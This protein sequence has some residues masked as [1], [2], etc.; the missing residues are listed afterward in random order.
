MNL[1]QWLER[2]HSV[3]QKLGQTQSELALDGKILECQD[4]LA[5]AFA[6]NDLTYA[7]FV[8]EREA[9][10][11]SESTSNLTPRRRNLIP[12]TPDSKLASIQSI[13]V[14]KKS[15]RND[16]I[17]ILLTFFDRASVLINKFLHWALMKASERMNVPQ[18][19]FHYFRVDLRFLAVWQ[20]LLFSALVFCICWVLLK[21]LF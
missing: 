10:E 1:I 20:N 13:S 2:A 19:A 8:K 14:S 5:H 7:Q 21:I 3:L 15:F 12:S 18:W 6:V 11:A 17:P 9:A 16:Q 4:E